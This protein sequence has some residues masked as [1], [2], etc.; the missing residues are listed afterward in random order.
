MIISGEDVLEMSGVETLHPG[1][2]DLSRRIGELVKFTPDIYVLDVSSGKGAFACLY[3]R[4]FGSHITGLEYNP[5]FVDIARQ[6][7]QAEGVADRVD[8]RVGDSRKLPFQ[9]NEFDVVVNECAVGLTAINAPRQVLGEMVRVAKAGGTI[10]IHEGTWLKPLSADEKRDASMRLGTTPYTVDEWQQMLI[11]AGAVPRIVEDWSGLENALK[12]R[13][14]LRWNPRNPLD[15][16]TTRE[17][18]SLLPR[19]LFR[20]GIG[21]MLD[22]YRSA[23]KLMRYVTD[24][25]QGYALII[26]TKG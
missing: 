1:G 19:L 22:L 24:G 20:Y 14:G 5:R 17:K 6:R 10:V 11:E 21:P 8:F 23:P 26:A 7:A 4:E 9:D 13:P 3:A 15:L 18:L 25:Y 12:I 16:L 2:Y